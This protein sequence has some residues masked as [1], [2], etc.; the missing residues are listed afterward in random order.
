MAF[1]PI[2]SSPQR[3]RCTSKS[4]PHCGLAPSRRRIGFGGANMAAHCRRSSAVFLGFRLS[5]A[6]FARAASSCSQ[7]C[8]TIRPSRCR[9]AARLNS[10]VSRHEQQHVVGMSQASLLRVSLGLA[11]RTMAR[12]VVLRL[13]RG[14]RIRSCCGS[15]ASDCCGLGSNVGSRQVHG[16]AGLRCVHY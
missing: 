12:S 7:G 13:V 15:S 14:A 5:S 16:Q 9:F 6:T 8:I 11:L 10:G 3:D 1:G 4:S 2:A